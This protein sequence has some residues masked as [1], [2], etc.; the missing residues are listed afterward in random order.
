MARYLVTVA[1]WLRSAERQHRGAEIN[2]QRGAITC[3]RDGRSFSVISLDIADGHVQTVRGILNPDKLRHL[4]P[5]ADVA[6]VLRSDR[7][8]Q[9]PAD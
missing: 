3:D 6:Q 2:G 1:R 9:G 5:V 8:G 4:G 7:A